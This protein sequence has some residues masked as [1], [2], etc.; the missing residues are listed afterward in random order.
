ML[1]LDGR[2]HGEFPSELDPSRAHPP[3]YAPRLTEGSVCRRQLQVSLAPLLRTMRRSY[4][5]REPLWRQCYDF[6]R[7]DQCECCGRRLARGRHCD[8]P[9]LRMGSGGVSGAAVKTAHG[10]I[11][12]VRLSY[13][14]MSYHQEKSH[15]SSQMSCHSSVGER[16][17]G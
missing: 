6:A 16:P 2:S 9:A 12:K 14:G 17:R 15:I 8:L 1:H 7:H 10:Q 11:S 13:T 5:T 4:A 3:R